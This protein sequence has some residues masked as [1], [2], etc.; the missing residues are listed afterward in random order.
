TGA[1]GGGPDSP[2]AGAPPP[3]VPTRARAI[4]ARQE[5]R[6]AAARRAAI[7]RALRTGDIL[8]GRARIATV[9]HGEVPCVRACRRRHLRSRS[10]PWAPRPVPPAFV[11][12]HVHSHYSLL[13]GAAQV[14]DLVEAAAR[15]EQPALALTDH[16]NLCGAIPFYKA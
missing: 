9:R 4:P 3:P 15:C 13:D 1:G 16:G 2:A 7:G 8:R 5:A 10:A 6:R 14:E 11:H 12:T